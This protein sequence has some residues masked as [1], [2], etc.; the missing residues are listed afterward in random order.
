MNDVSRPKDRAELDA[1]IDKFLD[2]T[3]GDQPRRERRLV[4]RMIRTAVKVGREDT[5]ILNLKIMD[6]TLHELHKGFATF[7][8]YQHRRKIAVFGSA[9][10]ARDS[11]SY[12]MAVECGKQLVEAGFMVVTGAGPG[13]MEAANKGAGREN[14][15]GV[16]IL[17]PFEAEAN[18]YIKGDPKLVDFRYFFTRKVVFVKETDGII[19]FPGGFGTQDEFFESLTLIQTGKSTPTPI[20]MVEPPG[21]TYWQQWHEYVRKALLGRRLISP[22]DLNLYRL[23]TTVKEAVDEV[24]SFYRNYYSIRYIGTNLVIRVRH[25]VGDDLLADLNTDFGDLI[26]DGRIERAEEDPAEEVEGLPPGLHRLRFHFR[27]K[28]FG[29]LRVLI[30]R[31]NDSVSAEIVDTAWELPAVHEIVPTPVNGS[32]DDDEDDA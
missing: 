24:T 10:S 12:E 9:R 7:A 15:F 1:L 4:R 8:P 21:S 13:I 19:L 28:Q 27:Q 26:V 11:R 20:V 16:N 31:L 30:D 3:V 17:L 2:S 6:R 29:R 5:P 14:S 32:E 18:E 22:G 25:P 23:T